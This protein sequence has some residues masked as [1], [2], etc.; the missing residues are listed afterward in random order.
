[1]IEGQLVYLR[2]VT[3]DQLDNLREWLGD[4][5]LMRSI[6]AHGLPAANVELEK[7]YMELFSLVNVRTL[8][9]LTHDHVLIGVV[10]LGNI[11]EHSRSAQLFIA[12]GDRS[13]WGRGFGPD[14][15]K[16]LVRYAFLDM[17]LQCIWAQIPEFNQRALR[18]F[19]KC[20]FEREGLLRN[21]FFSQGRYWGVVAAS[22]LRDAAPQ[23]AL[24]AQAA[25]QRSNAEAVP[26]GASV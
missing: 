7:W 14:A 12:I 15:I 1:M 3:K 22:V 10:A 4:P 25:T 9:I 24:D 19:E 6:A 26:V 16:T 18:A 20:G 2:P 8:A 23:P 21:R 5:S 17:N 11:S 13:Y